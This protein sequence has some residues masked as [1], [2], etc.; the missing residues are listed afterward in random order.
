MKIV[1]YIGMG[2]MALASF[3][4]CSSDYLDTEYTE[5]LDQDAAQQAG[6]NDPTAFLNGIWSWMSSWNTTSGD[7][8][9]DFSYMSVLHATDMMSEDIAMAGFHWFGYDYGF[10]N[11]MFNYRR[12]NVNWI[13]F[14]TMIAKANEI[15]GLYPEGG[16]TVTEKGLIGQ[17]YAVRG[18]SYYYLV[19]LYQ[20]CVKADGS[21]N[22]DAPAVPMKRLAIEG[23]TEEEISEAEGRNTVKDLFT[24]IEDDL[25]KAVENLKDYKRESKNEISLQVA[26]GIQARYYLLSQQWEKAEASAK[27]A[28]AGFSIM[29]DKGMQD[30]FMDIN[31]AEWMWGF[32]QN[33][34]TQTSFAS[35]FAMISAKAPGYAGLGYNTNLIDARLYS[36][37]SDTDLR[38]MYWFNGPEGNG[39]A[40]S[41][42]A[43]L[44]Y[45]PQKFGDDGNWTMDYIYMRAGEMVLIEA[46]ALARQNKN[47]DAAIALKKLMSMRDP[48]WNKTSVTAEDVVLQR[49]IELWGEGFAYFDLKRLNKGVDRNYQ[50]NNHL[51]GYALTVPAQDP[52]WTYQIPRKE[53]QENTHITE[54]DQNP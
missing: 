48:S 21:L 23:Y 46:E 49:R 1:K 35:F 17:A 36:K 54:D 42:G 38:K 14:Y 7:S 22:L 12:T 40:D 41:Y 10:D 45:A 37:M 51:A 25:G 44:P 3:S 43:S 39:E 33:T 24:Q 20:N 2:L 27:A 16:S 34:E 47:D 28:Q 13:T 53:L 18:L 50:G 8:H 4:S 11:R 52:A 29:D 9:D 6:N 32:D 15:I 5:N 26:L 31:N 30:G 19:Q